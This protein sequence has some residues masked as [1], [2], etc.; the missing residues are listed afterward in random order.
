MFRK[1]LAVLLVFSWV[2]LSGLDLLEDF[3]VQLDAGVQSPLEAPPPNGPSGI[4][5]VNNIVNSRIVRR[6]FT[7]GFSNFL[8]SIYPL[9]QLYPS[10]KLL[11]FISSTASF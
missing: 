8:R 5:V 1:S 6:R 4:N 7:S 10:K 2:I 3:D 11:D 9:T